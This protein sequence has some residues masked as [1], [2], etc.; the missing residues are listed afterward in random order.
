MGSF[1]AA[2]GPAPYLL[3]LDPVCDWCMVHGNRKLGL[4]SGQVCCDAATAEL[5]HGLRDGVVDGVRPNLDL[6]LDVVGIGKG[7]DAATRVHA[8][9]IGEQKA[10]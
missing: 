10:K 2:I 3:Q 1:A 7:D 6:M 4:G 9:S 8:A 5:T